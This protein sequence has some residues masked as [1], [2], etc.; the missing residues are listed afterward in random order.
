MLYGTITSFFCS[1]DLC[2]TLLKMFMTGSISSYGGLSEYGPIDSQV[3]MH[4]L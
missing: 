2:K 1:L 4:D 3:W